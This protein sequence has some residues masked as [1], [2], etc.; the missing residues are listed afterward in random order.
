[1]RPVAAILIKDL[2]L[3]GR[4]ILGAWVALAA[5]VL[6]ATRIMPPTHWRD[7]LA[8]LL[9]G[10]ILFILFY[11]DFL[12]EREK[13]KGTLAWLRTMPLSEMHLVTA[14]S[15]GLALM[16]VAG[17]AL[18]TLAAVP[19]FLLAHTGEF[20]EALLGMLCLGATMLL[21]RWTLG[22]RTGQV[23]PLLGVF[24]SAWG[25]LQLKKAFPGLSPWLLEMRSSTGYHILL[26]AAAAAWVLA[27]GW[28]LVRALAARDTDRLID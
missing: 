27:M 17:N 4:G 1:M 10:N 20:L 25:L 28:I 3:Y 7:P 6:L 9:C 12:V 2:Y 5:L 19:R 26:P 15:M 8:P 24:L 22:G 18:T 16:I 14:K 21:T 23:V 13:A 11:T